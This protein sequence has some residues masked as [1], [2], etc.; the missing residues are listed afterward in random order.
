MRLYAS[1]KDVQAE[2]TRKALMLLLSIRISFPILQRPFIIEVPKNHADHMCKE[3][4]R[5]LSI[6][7]RK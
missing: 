6:R 1:G 4:V 2:H 7:V 5:M 3:L